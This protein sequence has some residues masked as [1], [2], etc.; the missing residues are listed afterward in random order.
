MK[1]QFWLIG[2]FG[3]W[4]LLS[5]LWYFLSVKGV[6]IDPKSFNPQA[7]LIGILEILVMLLVACLLGYAIAWYFRTE[8][9]ENQ[10]EK[11]DIQ[12]AE[13]NSLVLARDEYK[14]QV[15]RWRQKH[16]H[17]VRAIQ[18][19]ST[20]LIS[21]KEKLQKAKA[22]LEASVKESRKDINEVQSRLQEVENEIGTLRYRNRQLEFQVK[23]G[24][25][26]GIKLRTE[27]ENLIASQKKGTVSDHPFVRA[28]E[29]DDKDDL[30]KIKGI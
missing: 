10:N 9:I 2:L 12:Q 14:N 15:E 23:E 29:P 18:Q 16:H 22:E 20:D 1:K 28:L 30:T 26:S 4:S 17:D 8:T 6:I 27:I 5:S 21:E 11:L 13:N 25:E 7:A 3:V 19:R 24:E